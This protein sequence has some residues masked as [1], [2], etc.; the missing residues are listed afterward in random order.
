MLLAHELP[1]ADLE[2]VLE[3]AQKQQDTALVATLTEQL[4]QMRARVYESLTVAERLA[5]CRHPHRP[6]AR[7]VVQAMVTELVELHGDRQFAEDHALLSGFAT[8]G[9]Q[10]CMIL[11]QDRGHSTEERIR[12]R[13]GM[14]NPEGYR[15]AVRMLQLAA[16]ADLP[17]VTMIDTPGAYPGLEAEERGQGWAI[18]RSIAEMMDHPTPIVSLILG[19]GCSGGALGLGIADRLAILE[20]GYYSVISPEGCASILWRDPQRAGQAAAALKLQAQDLHSAGFVDQ[21]LPEPLGGAHHNPAALVA[22][23]KEYL[24]ET[25]QA[26]QKVPKEQLLEARYQRHRSIG[27]LLCHE[28]SQSSHRRF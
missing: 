24:E 22:T 19:D 10:R 23:V 9:T 25:L 8:I 12:S 5:I 7:R 18:A 28:S 27:S 26:L 16:R 14:M 4:A 17:V 3:V 2:R 13:F 6:R 20:N 11:A 1:L 21:I 15:K